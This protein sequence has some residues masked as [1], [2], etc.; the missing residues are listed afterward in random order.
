MFMVPIFIGKRGN[1][2]KMHCDEFITAR[3]RSLRRLCFH[4]CLSVHGGGVACVA[5]GM[6]GSGCVCQG[7]MYGGRCVCDENTCMVKKTSV[8]GGHLRVHISTR[9]GQ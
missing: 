6:C 9:Y 2:G 1:Q 7:G 4:R 5:G 8:A 3:K